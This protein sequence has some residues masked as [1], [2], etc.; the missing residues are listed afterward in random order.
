MAGVGAVVESVKNSFIG[1]LTGAQSIGDFFSGFA[2]SAA[3]AAGEAMKLKAAQ[4]ELNDQMELQEITNEKATNQIEELIRQSEDM[5]LTEKQRADAIK[6]AGQIEADTYKQNKKLK[7]AAYNQAVNEFANGKNLTQQEMKMLKEKGTEYAKQLM[8]RKQVSQEEIDALK[9]AETE[10][11]K[12]EREGIALHKKQQ[13]AKLAED[14]KR[15]DDEQKKKDDAQRKDEDRRRRAEQYLNTKAEREKLLFELFMQQQNGKIKSL[16]QELKLAD[17]V[18]KGKKAIAD[19]EYIASEKTH[20]DRLRWEIAYNDASIEKSRTKS[21][22]AKRYAQSEF[23][24]WMSQH[25]TKLTSSAVITKEL[26][27]QEKQRLLD[28]NGKALEKLRADKDTSEAEIK[29]KE[30]T[31]QQLT[32]EENEFLIE[33]EN[34]NRQYRENEQNINK[35]ISAK[36]FSDKKAQLEAEAASAE[37][38]YQEDLINEDIRYEAEI[39]KLKERRDQGLITQQQYEALE[40]DQKR[41]TQDSKD[42]IEATALDNKLNLAQMG[43]SN[44]ATILGK[45]S[46]AGKAVAVAQATID[47]YKAAVAAYAAGVSVG[48][49]AGLVLGPVSAGLAV[50]AGLANVKKIVAT[51]EPKAPKAEQG[52][53]FTIG[54]NRHSAGGTMFTGQDGTRFEAEEGELIGVMNR[55]A[56]RH[57]MAFNNTFPAGGGSTPNYFEGGGIVSREIAPQGLNIDELAGKIAQANTTLPAPVVAVQDIITQADSYIKVR[58]AANF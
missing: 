58:D 9:K 26:L 31:N 32:L 3:S 17:E 27:G 5:S 45:E 48:G 14:A 8:Q 6:K 20:N 56:A 37:T 40:L 52:A 12:I 42:A 29:N 47:T 33:L 39:E 53:L 46:A 22:A 23:D 16:E 30:A 41:K 24:L 49:P 25:Q 10:K 19:A 55:N 57:F 51:K 1:L 15:L 4:Q 50:G 34:L 36:A 11:I 2:G 35:M 43:L 38:K 44:M 13:D 54:G 7:E 18:A 21:E 28:V